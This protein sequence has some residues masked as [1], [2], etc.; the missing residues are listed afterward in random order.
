MQTAF[1]VTDSDNAIGTDWL[2]IAY[3][4]SMAL[5]CGL[6]MSRM[7]RTGDDDSELIHGRFVCRLQ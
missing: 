1:Y 2:A 3:D 5:T 4:F 6:R 7:S